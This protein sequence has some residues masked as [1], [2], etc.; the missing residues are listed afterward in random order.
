MKITII[1]GSPRKNGNTA[2]AAR[3]FAEELRAAIGL[4]GGDSTETIALAERD[5]RRCLGCRV[6]FD[7]GEEACPLKDD[8]TAITR[9]M[10]D[11]DAV[12]LASPVY[13]DDVSGLMKTFIDRN[14]WLCHRPGFDG[15]PCFA[16]LT[17]AVTPSPHARAT[18]AMAARTWGGANVGHRCLVAG[19]TLAPG[20][21]EA[22]RPPLARAAR[23][24]VA[25]A[26][27]ASR[28]P[29]PSFISLLV[30]RVQQEYWHINADD[31]LDYRWW[32]DSGR[33]DRGSS[34]HRAHRG[35]ALKTALARGMG[36]LVARLV[37]RPM[38]PSG[39]TPS[40]RPDSPTRNA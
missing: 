16:L 3:V 32:R 1:N 18:L 12:V 6:C 19:G 34:W 25:A 31:S 27:T 38:P 35:S 17:T 37:L 30:Y 13:V 36:A 14:A 15:K 33:L 21:E 26:E 7:R 23:K 5:V 24:L 22:F 39:V 2:K 9:A 4:S 29:R 28:G 40:S 11:A 20:A 8:V 10:L